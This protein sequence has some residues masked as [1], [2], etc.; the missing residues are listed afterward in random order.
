MATAKPRCTVSMD[1]ELFREIEKFRNEHRFQTRSKAAVELIKL[2][3]KSL[4]TEKK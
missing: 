1:I 2:G 3:L 4:I